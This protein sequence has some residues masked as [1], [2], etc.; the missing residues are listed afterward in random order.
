MALE[1]REQKRYLN[2][3]NGAIREKCEPSHPSA[4][5]RVLDNGKV[6]HEIIYAS[7]EGTIDRIYTTTHKEYGLK[8][9]LVVEDEGEKYLLQISENSRYSND[10]IMVL[11]NMTLG[12]RFMFKPYQFT[13]QDEREVQGLTIYCEGEKVTNYY[14]NRT[15]K[16]DGTFE[17]EYVNGLLPYTGT[18][19]SKDEFKI[20]AMQSRIFLKNESAQ[21]IEKIN[22][23]VITKTASLLSNE[24]EKEEEDYDGI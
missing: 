13:T 16:A 9:N 24:D 19:G 22:D 23:Y 20:Y 7:L 10:F 12:S 5:K 8:Y 15:E 21:Y 11:P 3:S 6:L 4:V 2:M 18:N 1:Q 17:V 14:K